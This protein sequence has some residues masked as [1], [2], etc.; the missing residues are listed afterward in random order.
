MFAALIV[1]AAFTVMLYFFIDRL[2]ARLTRRFAG[3]VG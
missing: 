3:P 1:L 2:G